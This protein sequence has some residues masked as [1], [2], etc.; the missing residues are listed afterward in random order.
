M[1]ALDPGEKVFQTFYGVNECG[2]IGEDMRIKIL[3]YQTKIKK[4]Q[5]ALSCNTNKNGDNIKHKK[6]LRKKI[7]LNY[8][9]IKNLLKELHN[10]TC[11]YLCKNYETI[12]IPKFETQ[13]GMDEAGTGSPL[14]ESPRQF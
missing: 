11:N 12:M 1:A 7:I 5:K 9:K 8:R 14:Q 2:K 3:K 10:Q 13:S 4:F 6:T